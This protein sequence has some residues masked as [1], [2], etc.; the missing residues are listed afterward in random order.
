M[1]DILVLLKDIYIEMDWHHLGYAHFNEYSLFCCEAS[2]Q[3]SHSL[4]HLHN[5]LRKGTRIEK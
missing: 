5:T 1:F 4:P 2:Y 3:L